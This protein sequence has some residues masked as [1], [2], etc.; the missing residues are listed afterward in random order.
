MKYNDIYKGL[1]ELLKKSYSPYSNYP[2]AAYVDTD[3]GLIPGVN[4]ENGSLGLTSCAE[5]NAIFNAIT[6][7]AKVFKTVY[8]I[9][10]NNGDIGSPCGACRQVVSEFLKKMQKLLFLI[11]MELIRSIVSNNYY[12]LDEIQ[13]YL[14]NYL[15]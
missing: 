4:V 7:G 15:Q 13:M 3:I 1:I 14:Y 2:V 9:T 11:T 10:K 12:H 5:R 6:N 8:V